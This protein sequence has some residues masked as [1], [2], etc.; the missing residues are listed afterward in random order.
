MKATIPIGIPPRTKLLR[1]ERLPDI[2]AWHL[3]LHQS[4][5]GTLGTFLRLHNDGRIERVTVRADEGDEVFV[6]K[7]DAD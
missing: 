1:L 6:I 3:W 2:K 7:G 4:P 5:D